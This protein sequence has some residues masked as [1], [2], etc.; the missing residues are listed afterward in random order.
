MYLQKRILLDVFLCVSKGIHPSAS[1]FISFQPRKPNNLLDMDELDTAHQVMRN[2][3]L[4][5]TFDPECF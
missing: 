2:I 1:V 3:N 4:K 5:Q